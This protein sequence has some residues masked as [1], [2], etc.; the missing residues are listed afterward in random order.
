MQRQVLKHNGAQCP[1]SGACFKIH[2]PT[3]ASP[4][5]CLLQ[6]QFIKSSDLVL[7][8]FCSTEQVTLVPLFPQFCRDPG[9][10]S[11]HAARVQHKHL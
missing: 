10:F 8:L 1:F 3:P 9:F 4:H 7:K 2:T 6:V 5:R 11:S